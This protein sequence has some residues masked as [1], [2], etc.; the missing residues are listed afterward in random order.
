MG[1][2]HDCQSIC[3]G[4]ARQEF[5]AT[6]AVLVRRAENTYT[7]HEGEDLS[8]YVYFKGNSFH[9]NI[10]MVWKTQELS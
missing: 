5:M 1:W 2:G 6:I 10:I 7:V 9:S 3:Q 4:D 8:N